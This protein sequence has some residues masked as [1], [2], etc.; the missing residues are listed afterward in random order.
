MNESEPKYRVRAPH[1]DDTVTVYQA[2]APGIG[3]PAA[4]DG[5]FPGPGSGT[6]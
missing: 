3:G 5:R 1:T 4:R 2:Y 6:G